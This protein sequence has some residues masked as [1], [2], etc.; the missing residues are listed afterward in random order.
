[1]WIFEVKF[2]EWLDKHLIKTIQCL[3]VKIIFWYVEFK[4]M[5]FHEAITSYGI[6]CLTDNEHY[7]NVINFK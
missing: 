1:M 6:K 3:R 7:N 4:I 2:I 5:P